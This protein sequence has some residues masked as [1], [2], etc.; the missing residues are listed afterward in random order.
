MFNFYIR[1]GTAIEW[2]YTEEG[3]RVRVSCRTGRIIPI[4]ISSKE[5]VDY[6]TP[7]LYIEQSKD[8]IESDVKELTFE[9]SFISNKNK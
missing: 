7:E 5:T 9:V 4:P 8:T 2:R 1:K 3:N 6:K